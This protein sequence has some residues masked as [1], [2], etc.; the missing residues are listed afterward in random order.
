M[1]NLSKEFG[2]IYD[3]YID[4]I[5][6]FVF[7]K[8]DSQELAEDLSSETFLRCW[9]AF[10]ESKAPNP[11]IQKIEN[12]QA[13]LYQIARNLVIDHYREKGKNDVFST[14]QIEAIDPRINLEKRAMLNSDFN[15]VRLAIFNLKE[16]YQN[17]II[18]H[19]LDQFSISEIAK[20]LDKSEPATRVMLH[21][22]LKALK[23]ELV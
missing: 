15:R 2:E 8:V 6:R 21:R 13:F 19:Y 12:I 5:Y 11:G 17:V 23:K 4:K 10:K 18:W 20:M 3:K 7:L 22:A 9:E 1:N 14:E 16:D